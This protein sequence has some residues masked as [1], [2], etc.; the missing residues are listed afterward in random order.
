MVEKEKRVKITK[1]IKHRNTDKFNKVKRSLT[2]QE[3]Y[4]TF[5]SILKLA[6]H[7][8]GNKE[9]CLI[10]QEETVSNDEKR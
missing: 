1:I 5:I 4:N 10:T 7:T 8:P 6:G 3:R 9:N 2:S